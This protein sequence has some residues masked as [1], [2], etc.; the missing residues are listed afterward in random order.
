[1]SIAINGRYLTTGW[2]ILNKMT[3]ISFPTDVNGITEVGIAAGTDEITDVASKISIRWKAKSTAPVAPDKN[4]ERVV[5][6]VKEWSGLKMLDEDKAADARRA[7]FLDDTRIAGVLEADAEEVKNLITNWPDDADSA[8]ALEEL[9]AE[10]VLVKVA[11]YEGW[12]FQE[13]SIRNHVEIDYPATLCANTPP[14]SSANAKR[15]WQ[16]CLHFALKKGWVVRRGVATGGV[17]THVGPEAAAVN[18]RNADEVNNVGFTGAQACANVLV[19]VKVTW[20]L[21]NH[22]VGQND[23][24]IDSYAGK[25]VHSLGLVTDGNPNELKEIRQVIWIMGKI[26]S[27]RGILH[28]I[29]IKS[30]NYINGSNTG[31][32]EGNDYA[33]DGDLVIKVSAD[34]LDRINA[35]PAGTASLATYHAICMQATK[36]IYGVCV[37]P[38]TSLTYDSSTKTYSGDV[39]VANEAIK[40]APAQSHMGAM[41]L[42][43]D[44][45][46]VH[47]GWSEE[48]KR[49]LS[50]FIHAVAPN[51]TLARAP[52]IIKKEEIQGTATYAGIQSAKMSMVGAGSNLITTMLISRV[53]AGASGGGLMSQFG[54]LDKSVI[55]DVTDIVAAYEAGEV[56]DDEEAGASETRAHKTDREAKNAAKAVRRAKYKKAMAAI[57]KGL[58]EQMTKKAITGKAATGSSVP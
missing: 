21:I 45:R 3:T 11:S 44:A 39:Y 24:K 46:T 9:D 10:D 30:I 7:L 42:T 47:T 15:L 16:G 33:I 1:V 40:A 41:F 6:L 23:S 50:A 5:T 20:W 52:V 55:E 2:A 48:E 51:G 13:A 35:S 17:L 58:R 19:G 31:R 34:V 18:A 25:V 28:A 57:P 26:C 36:S 43:G 29:G 56:S 12:V 22:H 8:G 49:N 54:T 38:T 27:T 37:P 4:A 32:N 14:V 53:S